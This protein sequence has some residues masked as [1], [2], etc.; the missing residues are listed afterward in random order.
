MFG[1]HA[2]RVRG[3]YIYDDERDAVSEV[4]ATRKRTCTYL[5]S[6]RGHT[7]R[8]V[9]SLAI[10]GTSSAH[11]FAYNSSMASATPTL[12][13]TSDDGSTGYITPPEQPEALIAEHASEDGTPSLQVC[14]CLVAQNR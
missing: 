13:T 8:D 3:I 10:T 6:D 4:G 12:D 11:H 9:T 5:I 7:A 1:L 14:M 2:S